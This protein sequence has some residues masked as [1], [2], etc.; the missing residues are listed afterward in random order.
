MRTF[1]NLGLAALIGNFAASAQAGLITIDYSNVQSNA[2][3]SSVGARTVVNSSTAIPTITTIMATIGGSSS[4]TDIAYNELGGQSIIDFDFTHTRAGAASSYAQTF[5]SVLG[6]TANANTTYA[7]GG[8]YNMA[9][10]HRVYFESYLYDFSTHTYLFTNLQ[11]SSDTRNEAFV[12]G[13]AGGDYSNGVGGS[14]TGNL[15]LGHTYHLFFNAFIDARVHG[16][17]GVSDDGA[18]AVGNLTLTIGE[19]TTAVPEPASF[20]LLGLASL[21]GLG[22]RLRRRSLAGGA[23]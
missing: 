19:A 4:I 6:F 10:E 7:L 1:L 5:E 3:D 13:Q 22:L 2:R 14:L 18:S 16:V 12:L 21:G 15:T 17:G 8:F 11:E 20:A 23:A 9:G